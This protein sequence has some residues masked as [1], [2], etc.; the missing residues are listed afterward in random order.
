[1]DDT[2]CVSE[3]R[4]QPACPNC[5]KLQKQVD[6]LKTQLSAITTEL[7][8]LK[9]RLNQN[10]SNSSKPPSSDA[11]WRR[12]PSSKPPTG[13]KPGGQ[14]GHPG[15]YRERLPPE[16]IV[17]TI[18]CVPK[19]C[20]QCQAPLPK[21]PGP[22]DPAPT[23]HQ[24]TELPQR[25]AKVTEHQGHART[26]RKTVQEVF[27]L[28]KDFKDQRIGR[29]TLQIQM[30]M[31][32]DRFQK[33]LQRGSTGTDKKTK[34]FCRRRLKV[35][36]A[37]WTFVEVE[38][39]EPTNN[40]AE[41]MVRPA[42]LWRKNSFGSHSANG[43]R[44]AERILTTVQTLRLQ[45]RPVLDYLRRALIAHRSGTPTPTLLTA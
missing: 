19:T 25:S 7:R 29:A 36:P 34:R 27:A 43:C 13:R 40:H 38:G 16:R 14:P 35:Y 33:E 44:F 28:W 20:A 21:E 18:H 11:P 23:W 37:L 9:T 6:D 12:P 15:H 41:R 45:K 2:G 24:A 39:V 3:N 32:R 4:V 30:Q 26:G 17:H 22:K 5:D 10:S 31:A 1:V 42:V 8:D